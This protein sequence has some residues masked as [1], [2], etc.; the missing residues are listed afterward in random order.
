MS[1]SASSHSRSITSAELSSG[2]RSPV[3][4]ETAVV[5]KAIACPGQRLIALVQIRQP[6]EDGQRQVS[7]RDSPFTQLLCGMA[8]EAAGFVAQQ[9]SLAKARIP[10]DDRP[11]ESLTGTFV[12]QQRGWRCRIVEVRGIALFSF[13]S[14]TGGAAHLLPI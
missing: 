14:R 3:R 12:P 13:W 2:S 9:P 10:Q 7:Q 8:G 5:H 6:R 4:Q 1:R 11:F